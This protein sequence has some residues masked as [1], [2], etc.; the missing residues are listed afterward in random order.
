M[1][2]EVGEYVALRYAIC[3]VVE[4]KR[5]VRYPEREGQTT[6][7]E[8]KLLVLVQRPWSQAPLPANV[9]EHVILRDDD[10]RA[11]QS[12][13]R[14]FLLDVCRYRSQLDELARRMAQ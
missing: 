3:E 11:M 1:N 5:D 8:Y 6:M 13:Q 9:G 10:Y 7:W 4:K 12:L 14:V 2:L